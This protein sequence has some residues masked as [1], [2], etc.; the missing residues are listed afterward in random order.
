M[1]KKFVGFIA[2]IMATVIAL[3]LGGCDIFGDFGDGSSAS[4]GS[5]ESGLPQIDNSV[6]L[7]EYT[8][9]PD[10]DNEYIDGETYYTST[11]VDLVTEIH[12]NYTI[13][14]PFTLDETD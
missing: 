1:K 13:D 7:N 4:G 3:P 5:S 8:P 9:T 14:R 2:A 6:D 12:G 10:D 11:S